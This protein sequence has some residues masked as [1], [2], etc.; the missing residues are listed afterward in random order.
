MNLSPPESTQNSLATAAERFALLDHAPLGQMVVREDLTVLFWNRCLEL[1]TGLSRAHVV[2]RPLF[3]LFPHL[4]AAKYASRIHSVFRG[5][6]P[7]IFS[8]QLHPYLIPAPLPG[9]KFR[10]QYT[11]VTGIPGELPG[12]FSAIFAIQD[13]TSLTEAI[14]GHRQ[15]LERLL[16][17]REVRRKAEEALVRSS[18]ELKRLNRTLRERSISDGLTGM[19]N[20]RYFYQVLKRDFTM[21]QRSQSDYACLLLDL[22]H[23][24]LINDSWGHLFGDKVLKGIGQLLNRRFRKTDLVAR[25][26]GEEFAVLLPD[27]SLAA[28]VEVA[29]TVRGRIADHTFRYAGVAVKVTVSIG[30]ACRCAHRTASPTELLALA[31]QALYLAKERGRNQVQFVPP[32]ITS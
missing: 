27:V 17:E 7:T 14:D 8:A 25:Y 22:D 29:E 21:A 2:G 10:A 3:D 26:G 6:A 30:V 15:V 24:K 16:A 11:V 18:T 1:W 20:H 32:L 4:A 31:D 12:S 5:G 23:F 28:A 19:Y 9:G 13:V